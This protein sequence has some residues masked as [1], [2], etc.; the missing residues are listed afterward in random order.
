MGRKL[1]LKISQSLD[2]YIGGC[3]G[4]VDWIFKSFDEGLASWITD[5]L[6]QAGVHIMGSVTYKDMA[7]YWPDSS[8]VFAAPMNDIPKIVFSDSLKNAD[9]T[10][11]KILSSDLVTH[12]NKLKKEDGRFILAH[13]GAR[14]VQSLIKHDLID[15][16]R[17]IIHPAVVGKGL[18]IFSEVSRIRHF[19]VM[20][21]AHF[22]SGASAFILHKG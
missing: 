6:W 22:S 5:T 19:K 16:Y 14:F 2:G 11:T 9:W 15:E 17:L 1:I 8:E 3:N 18:P 4:E 20:S 10:E 7:E 21:A 12:I 13:G